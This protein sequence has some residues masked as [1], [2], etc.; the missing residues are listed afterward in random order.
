MRQ[1]L[2]S[3]ILTA[4][5]AIA[6]PVL[7]QNPAEI[8]YDQWDQQAAEAE[9]LLDGDSASQ[10][11]LTKI[12]AEMIDWRDRFQQGQN[13]NAPRIETVKEQI[14][15]L[16]PA[17]A[18]GASEDE[19]IAARRKTLNDQLSTLQAPRLSAVEAFSRADSIIKEIDN[20]IADRMATE[21]AQLSPSPLLPSSWTEGVSEAVKLASGVTSETVDLSS[22]A[23]GWDQMRDK[24]PPAFGYLALALVLLTYGRRWIET[25]PSRLSARASEHSRA[26]VAFLVSLGQIVLPML[27]VFLAIRGLDATGWF[28]NWSRPFLLAL[29]GAG[30]I[31]F[32]ARWLARQMY[33]RL[34]VAYDTLNMPERKRAIARNC[35]N[36]LGLVFALHHILSSALLPQSGIYESGDAQVDRVPMT[37]APGATSVWHFV[38]IVIAAVLLFRLGNVLRKM[39]SY[40]PPDSVRM[41]DRVLG[42]AGAGSRLIAV[43]SVGLGAYGLINLANA[44]IWPWIFTMALISFLILMQDLIADIFDMLSQGQEGARE[45][46]APLMVGA[47]LVLLSL[48]VFAVIWGATGTDLAEYW[49]R[50][51]QGVTFGGIN[52]SLFGLLKF[53]VVF[54][55]GYVI[56][57]GVQR[58]LRTAVL[59]K[60]R[61]DAGG[62]NALVSGLGYVGIFLAAVLAV[63]SAGID[64]SSLAIVAG[65]LSVGIGFGLQNIVSNFV[66][67]IILLIERPIS[68]GDWVDAGGQQG[69]V[70]RISVRSTSVETFDRTEVIV[71]NSDLVSQPV[72]NWTRSNRNG[73]VIIPV[74]VAYG[75][76][77]RRVE[78]ILR[79]IIEDQP[80]VM[81]DPPPA[82]LF[83]ALGADS[84][85]FEIRAILADASGGIG[86]TS[87]VLHAV[88]RRFGE[89][90]IEIPF[91]QR[92][93]WLRNPEA[94]AH[95][96]AEAAMAVDEEEKKIA[97]PV[98]TPSAPATPNRAD[99]R[100]TFDADMD[101]GD[102]DGGDGDGGR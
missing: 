21:L 9:Q 3:V 76:D 54:A 94:L 90:G 16:G 2:L 102:G 14:A 27:G 69:I 89:E 92:D 66:S 79:E 33:P 32:G 70:K 13:A 34:A 62:Q 24:L 20:Q 36:L 10:D 53:I 100:L 15:A 51:Q 26:V 93:I 43:L 82:V 11:Q 74:G 28:G 75:S 83:R 17:P 80:T 77:T 48:P 71:P 68:V 41:R 64:L 22:E 56:T 30:V 39:P 42:V 61:L 46:L 57:R 6:S 63:T 86:V 95:A 98:Q 1:F 38:M 29:P 88:V 101:A 52:L 87:D 40:N 23:G 7:A 8:N 31:F 4:L 19:E 18:E 5:I 84:M 67:G 25:L 35:T 12:R 97:A 91:V 37:F 81:I 65:A 96:G 58:A 49:N 50:I 72:T 45:G 78:Q 73:R 60:T 99:P 47:G 44:L 85:D 55:L 59:P